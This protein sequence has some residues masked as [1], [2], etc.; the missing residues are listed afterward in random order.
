MKVICGTVVK[1]NGKI[2][3]VQ[4]AQKKCYGQC[5]FPAGHLDENENIFEGAKRETKEETGYTVKLTSILSIQ[6][7]INKLGEHVLK[8]NFNGEIVSGEIEFDKDETLDVKWITIEE[9][10]QM[11]DKKIREEEFI[12]D[13]VK[14][15]ENNIN[16]PLDVIKNFM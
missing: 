2:L 9:L 14:D 16:Y 11:D 12:R 7:Y 6:N 1:Q 4:E 3:M 8:I 13:I 10:K 5:N 15:I